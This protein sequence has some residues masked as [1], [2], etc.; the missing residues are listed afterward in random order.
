ML[1]SNIPRGMSTCWAEWKTSR[2]GSTAAEP[3]LTCTFTYY[4]LFTF[5]SSGLY[6]YYLCLAMWSVDE[7]ASNLISTL[8]VASLCAMLFLIA[9]LNNWKLHLEVATAYFWTLRQFYIMLNDIVNNFLR[10]FTW[11]LQL[12]IIIINFIKAP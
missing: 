12:Y 1:L 11:S 2:L 4:A 5:L 3:S 6:L 10:H 7:L 9:Y 8:Y